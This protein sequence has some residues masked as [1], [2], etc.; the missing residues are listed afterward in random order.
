[1]VLNWL[2]LPETRDHGD[3]DAV[4]RVAIHAEIIQR[5]VFLTRLYRDFYQRIRRGTG[6]GGRWGGGGAWQRRRVY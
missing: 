3:L 4:D 5:K 6:A 1:M 2:K